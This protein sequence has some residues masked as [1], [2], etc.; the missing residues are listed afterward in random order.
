MFFFQSFYLG[1]GRFVSVVYKSK[2]ACNMYKKRPALIFPT[3]FAG[4]P[5]G[6]SIFPR[7]MRKR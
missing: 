1:L 3:N 4:K 6:P 5:F 2:L 7:A